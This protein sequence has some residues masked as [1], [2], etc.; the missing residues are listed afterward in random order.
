MTF[1]LRHGHRMTKVMLTIWE[2]G[3]ELSAPCASMN[4]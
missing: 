1:T 4:P 2:P 3:H